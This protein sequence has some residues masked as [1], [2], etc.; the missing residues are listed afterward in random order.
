MVNILITIFSSI[1]LVLGTISMVTPIP[2]GTILIAVSLSLLICSS[3]KVQSYVRY[4]RTKSGR[5]N[6]TVFWFEDKVGERVKFVG[7]AL[8][9]THPID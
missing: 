5:F 6:K 2:G 4:F 8:K 3:P 7:N 9:Q 1:L